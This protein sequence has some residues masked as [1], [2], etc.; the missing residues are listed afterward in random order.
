MG[1]RDIALAL[2]ARNV[3]V[4]PL[5]PR[6][7]A[8]TLPGW[9]NVA[10]T[11]T[12]KIEEWAK[13]FPEGNVAAVARAEID[14]IWFWEVDSPE[15][16]TRYTS[17]TGQ[18][19]PPTFRVRSSPGRGHFYFKQTAASIAMGN[20][21]QGSVKHGDF[22]VRVSNAYC[23]GPGSIHPSG[24][25]YEVLADRGIIK[26]PQILIN[27]L[28]AQ[29]VSSAKTALSEDTEPIYEPGRNN[30]LTSIGGS[31]RRSGAEHEEIEAVLLRIN[32]ARCKP[33]LSEAEVKVIARSVAGYA[34]GK[35]ETPRIGGVP[36][37]TAS[38]GSP[39]AASALS[40]KEI[41]PIQIKTH[42][43]PVFPE[44]VM[45][46][47]SLYEGFVKPVCAV[48]S[49][50]PEFMFMPALTLLL[51]YVGTKVRIEYKNI[52]PSLF[53]ALI[54]KRGQVIKSSSVEDAIQFFHYA[55]VMDQASPQINN[56]DGKTLVWTVGSPEG[57]G[58]DMNRTNCRNAVLFYDELAT[59][60]N[61]CG[62]D[63]STLNSSLLTLYE[64]GKLQN[65]IKSRKES[66]AL[67]PGTYCASLIVCSTDKNFFSNWSKL[68]GR[69][70]GLDDRFFMLYQ[71]QFLRPMIP[72]IE[73]D[74]RPAALVTR[75]LI[76][77]AIK[78][79]V[80]KIVDSSPLA[81][82]INEIGNRSE[83]R[84]EKF[85]LGFA[86]D[87]GLEEIDEDCIERGLALI[88]Y[89]LA[90]KKYFKT[91]E[92]TTRE[93]ALQMEIL[94][95]IRQGGGKVEVKDLERHLH[96]SRHGTTLWFQALQGLIK[97]G[98]IA[99]TGHGVKGDPK[100]VCLLEDII[101]EEE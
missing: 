97:A 25:V 90:A 33:P 63:S 95:S 86:I 49:R 87:L 58:L 91:F 62:I 46:G 52:I 100:I 23:V 51:N 7:K 67:D 12:E 83:I 28:I 98:R 40:P 78:K 94:Q 24:A 44:W 55:G 27:W 72:Q 9:Q 71:P 39:A 22:S 88:E 96:A 59:L 13:E 92:A 79:G 80:Y 47:T 3:P 60:T 101:D 20:I 81:S 93:G 65:T 50:Y 41:E 29:K 19:V 1:F 37:G 2:A 35:D 82:K 38:I 17:E 6:T 77:R 61:K 4:I 48:N 45:H 42:P 8:A 21:P 54:G 70:T 66:F 68:A 64:S 84:A 36:A 26:A 89:E 5:P 16:L 10:T 56:A 34:I 11:N 85:A 32:A 57:L 73:V 14:G 74:T 43:Y 15:V 75:K 18:K 53:L 69:S 31:L 30:R 76:D 99:E